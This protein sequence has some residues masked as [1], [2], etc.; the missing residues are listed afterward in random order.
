MALL[1][2]VVVAHVQAQ[3][4]NV[5]ANIWPPYV[6]K[7]LPENGLAMKIVKESLA[8]SGYVM[9]LRLEKWENALQGAKIGAYEVI[10]AIWK[11]HA[12]QKDLIFS[13]P[14]LKNN[15]VLLTR[16]DSTMEFK[17][18]NDLRGLL[19]GI[20]K[21]YAYDEKFMADASI[22]KFQA[23]R[24]TQNLIALE[25]AQL[26]AVVA[27]KRLA[28][29]ELKT[30]MGINRSKFRFLPNH[31]ATRQLYIAVPKGSAQGQTIIN[32][33]NKGL[34]AIKKDGTYEKI[35]ESYTY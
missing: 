20:L 6:D 29:Y 7:A 32:K 13:H 5:F 31:L 11:N 28:L 1:F 35:L 17:S 23:N 15:I 8:R 21:D 9:N 25:N 30:F 27:D 19:I 24:L 12:R 10:G 26:D 16:T 14:Y 2:S 22:L 33:F 4:I 3:N 18:L 34:A